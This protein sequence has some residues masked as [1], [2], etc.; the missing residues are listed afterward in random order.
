MR[1]RHPLHGLPNFTLLAKSADVLSFSRKR[2]K[3]GTHF[4]L[5]YQSSLAL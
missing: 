1:E 4:M 2:G 5:V 3:R